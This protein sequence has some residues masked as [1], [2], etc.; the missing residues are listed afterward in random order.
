M[1]EQIGSAVRGGLGEGGEKSLNR[2]SRRTRRAALRLCCGAGQR[3]RDIRALRRVGNSL[4]IGMCGAR[5][6]AIF[7]KEKKFV[8]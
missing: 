8:M 3:G 7:L 1:E 2:I 6:D 4:G 5:M